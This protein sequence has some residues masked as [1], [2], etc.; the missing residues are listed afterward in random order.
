MQLV[1]YD[2]IK[3]SLPSFLARHVLALEASCVDN[4]GWLGR[5]ELISALDAYVAGMN[6]PPNPVSSVQKGAVTF[7]NKSF[8]SIFGPKNVSKVTTENNGQGINSTPKLVTPRRCFSCGATGHLLKNCPDRRTT[9][10]V[11]KK[12][13][14]PS[15]QISH[16]DADTSHGSF[17]PPCIDADV[18][19]SLCAIARPDAISPGGRLQDT[20]VALVEMR[21]RSLLVT[22]TVKPT[23]HLT[24]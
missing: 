1:I 17:A 3:S 5:Q 12:L 4:G 9:F 19:P 11:G 16:C 20:A 14:A 6:N 13:T 23:L 10:S 7:T 22:T 15:Q 24:M 21:S 18:Q 8:V 2:R